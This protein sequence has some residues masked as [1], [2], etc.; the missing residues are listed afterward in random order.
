MVQLLFSLSIILV[1]ILLNCDSQMNELHK[2]GNDNCSRKDTILTESETKVKRDTSIATKKINGTILDCALRNPHFDTEQWLKS[3]REFPSALHPGR[4]SPFD[5]IIKKVS[6]RYG[7]DWRLIAAQIFVESRF[8]SAA[9]SKCG[10]G[11]LMQ[12]MPRTSSFLGVDPT[13]LHNPEINISVGCLYNSKLLG[14]WKKDIDIDEHRL[15]FTLASYNAGR[16]RVLKSFRKSDSLK[17]WM[18]VHPD[19]PLETQNYVHRI[20]LKHNFYSKHVLP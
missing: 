12:V 9:I 2:P 7:F 16:G 18:V 17:T 10:A 19:L 13:H 20:I 5:A 6:R 3:D 8:D 15:A 14:L 11:G 1:L 4:I